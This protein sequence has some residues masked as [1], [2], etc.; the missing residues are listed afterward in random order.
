MPAAPAPCTGSV[1]GRW[2]PSVRVKQEGFRVNSS[3]REALPSSC[4]LDPWVARTVVYPRTRQGVEHAAWGAE[5]ALA[6]PWADRGSWLYPPPL[7]SDAGLYLPDGPSRSP[8]G[9]VGIACSGGGI[10]AAAFSLGALQVLQAHGLLQGDARAEHLTAVSGSSYIAAGFASVRES[11]TDPSEPPA[12]SPGSPEERYLRDRLDYLRRG[13]EGLVGALWRI[14]LG[15]ALNLAL[16]GT[17]LVIAGVLVGWAYGWVLPHVRWYCGRTDLAIGRNCRATVPAYP[18]DWL[19]GLIAVVAL[20]VGMLSV[21]HRGEGLRRLRRPSGWLLGLAAASSLVLIGM[22]QLLALLHRWGLSQPTSTAN[23][24]SRHLSSAAAAGAASG[25]AGITAA[26]VPVWRTIA[27]G[28]P[29]SKNNP[30]GSATC[31]IGCGPQH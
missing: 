9:R 16:L 28:A 7:L 31:F 19:V 27:A 11:I 20:L 5:S 15:I 24:V 30:A 1:C 18:W 6:R 12:F 2:N 13:R 26:L 14:L 3:G 22:P 10:R 17:V 23:T 4:S 8:R 29:K 25:L 21:L